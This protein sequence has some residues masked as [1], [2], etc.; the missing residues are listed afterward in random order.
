[1]VTALRRGGRQ[2]LMHRKVNENRRVSLQLSTA[3]DDLR[4]ESD[5]SREP[6][7]LYHVDAMP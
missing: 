4:A 7:C 2:K 5:I 3:L 1:M 6:H